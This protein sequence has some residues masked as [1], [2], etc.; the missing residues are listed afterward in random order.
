MRTGSPSQ[1][2]DA[3][4]VEEVH[5]GRRVQ[6]AQRPIDRERIGVGLAAQALAQHHLENVAGLDV[7][8]GRCHIGLMLLLGEVAA[9]FAG[10]GDRLGLRR[11]QRLLDVIDDLLDAGDGVGIA[12]AQ[13]GLIAFACT[14][15]GDHDQLVAH[16]VEDDQVVAEEH[17]HVGHV[18]IVFGRLRQTL[19]EAHQIV[20]EI[21]DHAA[22]EARQFRLRHRDGVPP[23]VP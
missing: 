13:F 4:E 3:A 21:A 17:H 18:Q 23:S 22:V 8:L 10:A 12:G 1:A 16:M 11:R 9:P 6:H 20:A 14:H 19:H 15:V 2:G 5:V 7:L